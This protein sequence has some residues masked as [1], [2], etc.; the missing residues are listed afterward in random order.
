MDTLSPLR[1]WDVSTWE[2]FAIQEQ[3]DDPEDL[4]SK[5]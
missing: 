4:V 2:L 1:L 3:P 5:I